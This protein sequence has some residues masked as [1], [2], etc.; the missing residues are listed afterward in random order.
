MK[1]YTLFL[2]LGLIA[3]MSACHKPFEGLTAILSNSYIDYRVSLQVV[4]ANPKAIA[5]YPPSSTITLTGDAIK[6]GLIY[7]AEGTKATEEPGNVPLV[8][9]AVTLAVKPYVKISPSA[10]LKF[11]ITASAPNY[12]TNTQD[13]V[14][15]NVDSLQY[16]DVKLLNLAALPAGVS[17]KATTVNS[18]VNG[19]TATPF[20][21][22]VTSK[23]TAPSGATT[24]QTDATVTFPAKTVFKDVNN[25]PIVSGNSLAINVINFN[26]V[27][28]ES[29]SA[30]PGGLDKVTTNAGTFSFLLGGAVTITAT[31]G[32]VPVKS[33][34]NPIAVDIYLPATTYNPDAKAILKAGDVVPVWS[35]NEGSAIWIKEGAAT[36]VVEP[37]TGRLKTV[38][39]VTHLSTWMV[40]FAQPQCS[41]PLQLTYSSTDNLVTPLYIGVYGKEGNAQLVVD[42]V[43]TAKN[44]DVISLDL[45][46]GVDVNVKLYTGNSSLGTL[47][48]TVPVLACAT[49]ASL[50]NTKSNPNP[51]LF[52]DLQTQCQNG[53]FRYS[54]PIDYRVTGTSRWETFTPSD[55][56]R[57]STNLLIWNQTYDFRIIYKGTQYA[58]T[59]QVLQDEFRANG[60]IWEYFGKTSVKQ[61]FFNAPTNCN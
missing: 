11:T 28:T 10:P 35:K 48:Q 58:R 18:I 59:K 20:T 6:Q 19:T 2:F 32:T 44:G 16:I 27:S 14:I 12:I 39:S 37:S 45:P 42:K 3:L 56:G 26:N 40:A 5:Y 21:V 47:V 36:V 22:T 46:Q 60:S 7:T 52:F 51:T 34:S 61:T 50:N 33:F 55:N 57:L 29:V 31:L 54:G 23:T 1:K 30:L 53:T 17:T 41:V 4:N 8:N 24:T 43:V 49:S 13:V 9:N 15:T 25:A 38:V